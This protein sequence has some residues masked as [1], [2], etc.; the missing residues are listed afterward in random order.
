MSKGSTNFADISDQGVIYRFFGF[1]SNQLSDE[2][3]ILVNPD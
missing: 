2:I 3:F 1:V